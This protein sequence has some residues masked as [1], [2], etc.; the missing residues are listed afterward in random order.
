MNIIT[1]ILKA[2][3][4]HKGILCIT[5]RGVLKSG[6][7]DVCWVFESSIDK[8]KDYKLVN[9]WE[10]YGGGMEVT[11]L[12]K[13]KEN[14]V[15]E[16]FTKTFMPQK[17]PQ[18]GDD[19]VNDSSQ[20]QGFDRRMTDISSI[21][22]DGFIR[23]SNIL[24]TEYFPGQPGGRSLLVFDGVYKSTATVDIDVENLKSIS[25]VEVHF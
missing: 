25:S 19:F 5:K 7:A 24:W 22:D 2:R 13:D 12:F 15:K 10:L 14:N 11:I 18:W 21:L 3:Q 6:K 4:E 17:P 20:R 23:P 16:A 1:P 8:K 9:L